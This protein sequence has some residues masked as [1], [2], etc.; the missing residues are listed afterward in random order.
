MNDYLILTFVDGETVVIHDDLRFD[1]NL[2]PELSFAFDALYFE[3]PSGH[4]VKR[5]DGALQPLSEAELEECA[6]YCRGYAATADYPVYAWNGDN[7]SVGRFVYCVV[8]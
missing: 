2:K 1:T 8:V 7:I 6:A 3:P 5:V 4:C